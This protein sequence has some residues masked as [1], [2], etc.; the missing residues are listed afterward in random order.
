M[1]FNHIALYA[2]VFVLASHTP[3]YAEDFTEMCGEESI[4]EQNKLSGELLTDERRFESMEKLTSEL[5]QLK[6]SHK[7]SKNIVPSYIR[8]CIQKKTIAMRKHEENTSKSLLDKYK[9]RILLA[10]FH[11]IIFN[12][13]G[14]IFHFREAAKLNTQDVFS[15]KKIIELWQEQQ[16]NLGKFSKPLN[17]GEK[18]VLVRGLNS[19]VDDLARA[20]SKDLQM[21]VWAYQFRAETLER[22][23]LEKESLNDWKRIL[24]LDSENEVALRQVSKYQLQ[25]NQINE[26]RINLEKLVK[27]DKKQTICFFY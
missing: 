9:T 19:N 7:R 20:A 13:E 16:I 1:S 14:A 5:N 23:G 24:I 2:L 22:I 8:N 17:T 21:K 27:K 25:S 11:Q 6:E 4:V 12:T 3:L 18:E 10:Q 15:R 26:A